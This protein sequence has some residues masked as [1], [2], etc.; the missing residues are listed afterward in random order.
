MAQTGTQYGP[1]AQ[2]EAPSAT[3]EARN[4]PK[5]G[6]GGGNPGVGGFQ[7]WGRPETI[8][9]QIKEC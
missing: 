7:L 1:N 2:S 3:P 4:E 9:E 5:T 6:E 8:L